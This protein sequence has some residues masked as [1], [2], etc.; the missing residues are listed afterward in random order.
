MAD[1]NGWKEVWDARAEALARI[2]GPVHDQLFHA[3]HPFHLGGQADVVAFY[4][5]LLGVVYVT[6]ELTG[7]LDARYADYELMIC[8][9]SPSDWSTNLISRL[10][11]YTQQ[12]H[13]GTGESMDIPLAL[14]SERAHTCREESTAGPKPP[15]SGTR[16]S[17]IGDRQ[18]GR[19]RSNY[20]G[21]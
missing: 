19:T 3:A 1:E 8:Q 2:L 18:P 13:I 6:A 5:H 9:R 11:P 15:P 16:R 21:W 7:K 17:T 14:L 10:A 12:A 20:A 4:A